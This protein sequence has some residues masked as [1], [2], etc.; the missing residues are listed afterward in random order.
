MIPKLS[1]SRKRSETLFSSR[2]L[3]FQKLPKPVNSASSNIKLIT[4]LEEFEI[5]Y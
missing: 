5:S 4:D 2:S 3:C 1:T